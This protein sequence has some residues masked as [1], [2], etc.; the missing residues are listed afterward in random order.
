M[1]IKRPTGRKWRQKA[2]AALVERDGDKCCSCGCAGRTIWR[3]MGTWSGIRWGS[4]PW[5][6][7]RYTKVNPSSNLEVDHKTALSDGGDN[8]IGNLWLLCVDCHK[9]KTSAERSRRLKGLFAE[10]RA[11]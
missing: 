1:S 9:Q 3:Q 5:E 10:A 4:D 11:A 6:R 7:N 2:F 8:S